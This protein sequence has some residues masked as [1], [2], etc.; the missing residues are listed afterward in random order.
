MESIDEEL[1]V[2][3]KLVKPL[4]AQEGMADK[5]VQTQKDVLLSKQL[6]TSAV[7]LFV[8][9]CLIFLPTSNELPA[10]IDHE[11]GSHMMVS[12]GLLG[13]IVELERKSLNVKPSSPKF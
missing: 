9:N 10:Q 3:D 1:F 4:S 5:L 11:L 12:R 6:I 8:K 13:R 7:L 2:V